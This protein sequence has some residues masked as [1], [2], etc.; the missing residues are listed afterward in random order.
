MDGGLDYIINGKFFANFVFMKIFVII[1]SILFT[2]SNAFSQDDRNWMLY[3]K[4][5][6]SI[7]ESSVKN[8]STKRELDFSRQN[9]TVRVNQ[10][11]AIDSLQSHFGK[12]PFIYGYTVQIEVSQQKEV[13]KNA[14]Y[15]FFKSYPDMPL[16]EFYNQPNTYL[17]GGRF[18]DKNTAYEFKDKIKKYFPD[19]IVI[20]KK[21]DLPP[22][23]TVASK[24]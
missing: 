12:A 11:T 3:P 9:G 2:F 10:P 24:E 21:M 20:R 23:K 19:A 16:D 8:D 7:K 15:R 17:Y 4:K 1:T 22:L 13:I 6:A 14:R 5:D 18:Y